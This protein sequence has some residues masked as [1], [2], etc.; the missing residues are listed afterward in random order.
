MLTAD[1]HFT[2]GYMDK[3]CQNKFSN[4]YAN[5]FYCADYKIG[6]FIEWVQQQ[7][8]YK[9]TSIVIVGDHLVV[10]DGLYKDDSNRYIYNVLINSA[11]STDNNKNR[12]AT[13]FDMYPTTIAALGA[14]IDGD[15]LGL[16]VNLYSSKKTLIEEVGAKYLN[17]ELL[18]K[19]NYYNDYIIGDDYYDMINSK[20]A[21]YEDKD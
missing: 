2:D 4:V 12:V 14:K 11:L 3:E 8:F 20:E 16:G 18:K 9:N 1:T 6:K 17:I 19:S 7:S 5:S 15:K 21:L 13:H 10:Q